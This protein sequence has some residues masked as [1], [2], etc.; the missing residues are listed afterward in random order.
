M[1]NKAFLLVIGLMLVF[2]ASF[3]QV[4]KT[5]NLTIPGTLSSVLNTDEKLS[6]TSLILTGKLDVRDFD[7]LNEEMP[8]LKH[9]DMSNVSIMCHRVG[10]AVYPAHEIPSEAFGYNKSL[11]KVILPKSLKCIGLNSFIES[12]I[13]EVVLH[14]GVSVIDDGCFYNCL[15]LKMINIPSSL[16]IIGKNAFTQTKGSKENN[17]SANK[18]PKENN[19]SANK[20][21]KNNNLTVNKTPK[22]NNLTVN[23]A[24]K[25]NNLTVNKK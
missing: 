15:N 3:G 21:P 2:C 10:V 14:D 16:K 8:S 11:R 13:E 4:A 20:T 12:D 23:K 7:F 24:P 18:T 25:N 19:L 5:I 1:L 22:N 9:L 17:L 6:I